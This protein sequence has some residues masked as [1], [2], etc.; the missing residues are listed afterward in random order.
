MNAFRPVF[1]AILVLGWGA[2]AGGT[3]TPGGDGHVPAG[4]AHGTHSNHPHHLGLFFGGATRND[5]GEFDDTG[6]TFGLEYEYR[7]APDWGV[8]GV[9]E[10]VVF[11]DDH[12]DLAFAI[13]VIWHPLDALSLSA[14]PGLETDGGH[15]TFLVRFAVAYG[16]HLRN[17]TFTPTLAYDMT[18]GPN[19]LVYGF[20]IGRGF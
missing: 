9:V 11:A 5:D 2:P 7:F 8:G 17:F 3:E 20:A 6:L 18:S 12:R 19:T 16:F 4:A 1:A 14:G 15:A 10:G 13:P